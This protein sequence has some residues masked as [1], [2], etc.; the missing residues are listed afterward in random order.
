MNETL[1]VATNP[2]EL[3]DAQHR[4]IA[5]VDAKLKLAIA[6]AHE[7][8]DMSNN[9]LAARLSPSQAKAI[10]K[11]ATER[12]GYL[13]RVKA[14]LEAGYCMMPDMPGTVIAVRSARTTPSPSAKRWMTWSS[15]IPDERATANLETGEG[16][17]ISPRQQLEEEKFPVKNHKGEM[18]DKTHYRALSL[19]APD[20]I[21]RR[22]MRPRVVKQLTAAMEHR[23]FDEIVCVS[24]ANTRRTSR[25]PI[26]LGRVVSG[27]TV[28]AFLIAWFVDTA[29]L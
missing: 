20:G 11:R 27:R 9:M 19:R 24:P 16:E 14:A 6:E 25:D 28:S 3:A 18:E 2:T 12:C 5:D 29:E 13:A 15:N 10:H 4:M 22:F 26:V 17:Y 21:D 7:A 23:I 1:I 8:K